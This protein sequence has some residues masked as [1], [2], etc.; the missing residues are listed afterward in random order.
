MTYKG[1]VQFDAL[2]SLAFGSISG[3]YAALGG[4]FSHEASIIVL[5][6][7]TDVSIT[8]SVDG[9][10]DNL[11]IPSNG[12]KLFDFTTNRAVD[13]TPLLLASGTQFYAKGT[14][15]SGSVILEVI[16]GVV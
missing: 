16:Y 6:N 5:S 3:T 8:F 15:S 4:P 9:V 11:L 14:P 2:R 12:F 1:R 7:L 10:T 13:L